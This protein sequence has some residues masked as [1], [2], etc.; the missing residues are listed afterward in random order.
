MRIIENDIIS[1]GTFEAMTIGPYIFCKDANELDEKDINHEAI[2]WEQQKELLIV[3]FYLL[4]LI[5]WIV[6][7]GR[8]IF[9][10]KRGHDADRSKNGVF[11]RAYRSIAFEREAYNNQE[12]LKYIEERKDYAWI[13]FL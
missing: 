8:C 5:F 7:V 13:N 4:Y 12:N 6:E 2:H 3:G 1:F 9:D 11:K 10:S